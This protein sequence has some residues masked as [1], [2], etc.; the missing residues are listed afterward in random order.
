M[1]VA[2]DFF[3]L[4]LAKAVAGEIGDAPILS[5]YAAPQNGWQMLIKN[6]FDFCTALFLLIALAPLMIV[7]A[8]VI[9]LTSEGGVF[10]IQER[11]GYNKR[12]FKMFKFFLCKMKH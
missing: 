7:I 3:N 8:L 5:L 4:R 1:R 12:L 6:A 2:S 9:K 11:V 10:F